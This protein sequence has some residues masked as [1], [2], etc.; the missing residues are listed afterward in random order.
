MTT[1]NCGNGGEQAT[2]L[3]LMVAL[4][5]VVIRRVI[6]ALAIVDFEG[7]CWWFCDGSGDGGI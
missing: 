3:R 6:V 5:L 7:G 1:N 4:M 2:N